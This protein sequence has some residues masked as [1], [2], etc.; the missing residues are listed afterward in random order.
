MKSEQEFLTSI[1]SEITEKEWEAKQKQITHELSKRLFIKE[2]IAYMVVLLLAIGSLIVFFVKNNPD[3][4]Y[5]VAIV[6]LATAFFS[7][8]LLYSKS[9]EVL[10]DEN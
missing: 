5:A 4:T 1:W 8:K 10:V 9:Q 2:I 3:I 6:L 7:E